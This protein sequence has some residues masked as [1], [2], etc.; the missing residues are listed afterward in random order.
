MNKMSKY[1]ASRTLREPLG[2]N[3]SLLGDDLAKRSSRDREPQ[4]HRDN[5]GRWPRRMN[6]KSVVVTTPLRLRLGTLRIKP[7]PS[8]AS[9]GPAFREA[10]SEPRR[11]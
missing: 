7:S 2:W 3:A 5:R 11:T 4:V 6:E 9:R 8:I 1:V 10:A